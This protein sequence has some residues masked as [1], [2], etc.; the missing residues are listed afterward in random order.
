[1]RSAAGDPV[2]SRRVARESQFR[3]G[4]SIARHRLFRA[5]S[6]RII[7][8]AALRYSDSASFALLP[9]HRGVSDVALAGTER[10]LSASGSRR[11]VSAS[12]ET[13]S[14]GASLEGT[15]TPASARAD[16]SAR[17]GGAAAY[18]N[19]QSDRESRRRPVGAAR[20]TR[21]S[22]EKRRPPAHGRD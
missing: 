21:G 1:G 3:R 4:V 20:R 16:R 13:G 2:G 19:Q 6:D 8:T 22:A 17:A 7:P 14:H 12:G 5:R 15:R 10:S 11:T 18:R 9:D